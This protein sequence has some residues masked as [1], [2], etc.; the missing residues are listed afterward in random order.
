M[1]VKL[2]ILVAGSAGVF[3][4]ACGY[5]LRWLISLGK[6]GSV[7]LRIK[8][9]ELAAEVSAKRVIDEAEKRAAR[10]VE[11]LKRLEREKEQTFKKTEERLVNKE[12]LLD[13]RQTGLE[14]ELEALKKKVEEVRLV[15]ERTLALETEKKKE[16]ERVAGLSLAEAKQELFK[17]LEREHEEDVAIQMHKL[18]KYGTERL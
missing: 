13:K 3:G 7:E 14:Q 8:E 17:T 9:M 11:D 2:F 5:F 6:R 10:S 4:I 15:K 16:I 1:G 18:E 12:D